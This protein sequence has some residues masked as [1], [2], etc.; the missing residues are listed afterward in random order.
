[1]QL[2]WSLRVWGSSVDFVQGDYSHPAMSSHLYPDCWWWR[3]HR[4]ALDQLCQRDFLPSP[5]KNVQQNMNVI[6]FR[7]E[8]RYFA[9]ILC[10]LM[11]PPHNNQA[12]VLVVRCALFVGCVSVATPCPLSWLERS[13]FSIGNF[14]YDSESNHEWTFHVASKQKR[15][16]SEEKLFAGKKL[17]FPHF[18]SFSSSFSA[19]RV[20][21]LKKNRPDKENRKRMWKC[22][23]DFSSWESIFIHRT[24]ASTRGNFH[25]E[26]FFFCLRY[27]RW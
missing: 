23:D 24:N 22:E 21:K 19:Q 12:E 20:E 9:Y 16:K 1:M 8:S 15:L 14:N 13:F 27:L 4:R 10:W 11:S 6:I 3:W 25:C 18:H 2:T 26:I 7:R 5:T 17:I